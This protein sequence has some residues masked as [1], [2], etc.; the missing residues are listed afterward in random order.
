M[1]TELAQGNSQT[2]YTYTVSF[3]LCKL[4]KQTLNQFSTGDVEEKMVWCGK[5]TLAH[6][7]THAHTYNR[8]IEISNK[9]H[10]KEQSFLLNIH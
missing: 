2:K 10:R 1:R 6:T 5:H 3:E 8:F 4:R 9:I 7:N